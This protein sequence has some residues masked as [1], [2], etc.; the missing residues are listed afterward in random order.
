MKNT[1][2]LANRKYYLRFDQAYSAAAL[3]E[4]I[5][6]GK[7]SP[8]LFRKPKNGSDRSVVMEIQDR[9]GD[10]LLLI[11]RIAKITQADV[12]VR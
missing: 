9:N 2:Q 6:D 4:W 1:V 3:R 12:F 8:V 11:N 7:N 10:D 5:E